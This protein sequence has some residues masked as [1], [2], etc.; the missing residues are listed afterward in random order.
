MDRREFDLDPG[1]WATLR[2]LLDEALEREPS[3]RAAWLDTLDGPLAAFKPR[4]RS[5]LEHAQGAAH[6]LMNT[7]PKVET[8]DFAPAPH[9]AMPQ[10]IGTYRLMLELGSRRVRSAEDLAEAIGL[11]VLASIASTLPAPTLRQTLRSLFS[12]RKTLA[13]AAAS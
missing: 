7:L 3:Q 9:D 6:G 1:Q 5:L 2:R 13:A 10:R 11:P 4:L 12:R 8:A